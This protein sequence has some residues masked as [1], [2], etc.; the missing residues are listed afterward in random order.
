MI[1]GIGIDIL[2]IKRLKRILNSPKGKVFLKAVFTEKEINYAYKKQRTESL[3]TAFAAKEAVF[4]SL[5]LSESKIKKFNLRDIEIL[6]K[7]SGKPYVSFSG[8]LAKTFPKKK[9]R[10]FLSLS[11]TGELAAA[12]VIAEKTGNK[13]IKP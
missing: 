1:F 8:Y 11:F 2:E 5:N 3:A 7:I 13:K 6:R 9:F 10:F 4:K 12:I